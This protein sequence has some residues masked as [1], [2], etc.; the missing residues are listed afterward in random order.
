MTMRKPKRL[1]QRAVLKTIRL[2]LGL[3]AN[4]VNGEYRVNYRKHDPRYRPEWNGPITKDA[5]AGSCYF[6]NDPQDALDTAAA[7]SRHKK[8]LEGPFALLTTS[9]ETITTEQPA[10]V[11]EGGNV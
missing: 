9:G 5:Q 2:D 10:D 1:T 7:M 3:T 11:K 4:V 6:T 8:H